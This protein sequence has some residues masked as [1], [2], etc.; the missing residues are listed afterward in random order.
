MAAGPKTPPVGRGHHEA[1]LER[2]GAAVTRS[3]HAHDDTLRAR[4]DA[5]WDAQ[6]FGLSLGEIAAAVGL[7][8]FRIQ[9]IVTA[10]ALARQD[11]GHAHP[12]KETS[13]G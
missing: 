11:D 8:R 7:S 6:T 12:K 5:I 1:R 4:A 9:E 13:R 2:L 10:E 3:K